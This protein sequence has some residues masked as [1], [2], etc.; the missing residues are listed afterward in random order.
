MEG[1]WFYKKVEEVEK[2]LETNLKKGLNNEEV[3]KRQEKYGFNELKEG[4]KKNLFQK[5]LEQ[6]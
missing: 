5:F 2:Q 3:K 1:N 4:K 6:F